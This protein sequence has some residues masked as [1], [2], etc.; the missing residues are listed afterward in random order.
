MKFRAEDFIRPKRF[1]LEGDRGRA[2]I[3]FVSLAMPVF[4]DLLKLKRTLD[5]LKFEYEFSTFVFLTVMVTIF[6]IGGY[7]TT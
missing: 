4:E 5:A 2:L 3:I 1:C 7:D 6:T